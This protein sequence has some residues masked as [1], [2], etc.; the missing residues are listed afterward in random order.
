MPR[1]SE[2]SLTTGQVAKAC[3]VSQRTVINWINKGILKAYTLPGRG[4]RR[5]LPCDLE[6]FM[7]EQGIR[8]GLQ[9]KTDRENQ[10]IL[11]VDDDPLMLKALSRSIRSKGY[12]VIS[13][14][15]GFEAGL[16][17][18]RE[19]PELVILDLQMPRIDGFQVLKTIQQFASTRTIVISG[20][21]FTLLEK[22]RKQGADAVLPKPFDE[23]QLHT[24]IAEL[25][26]G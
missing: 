1:Y 8:I 6:D 3:D 18:E 16:Q 14:A 10:K 2:H 12:K 25:L 4:D 24:K 26:S 9:S 17:L 21:N 20:A 15:D 7:R 22:A 13:A 11:I 5:V 19:H 23:H